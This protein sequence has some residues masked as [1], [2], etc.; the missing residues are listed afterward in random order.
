M[1]PE[2]EGK[3]CFCKFNVDMYESRIFFLEGPPTA[4]MLLD[5]S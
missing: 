5:S 2:V 3:I 4:S 1:W